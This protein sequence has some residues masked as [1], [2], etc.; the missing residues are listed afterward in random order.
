MHFW[1]NLSITKNLKAYDLK[2]FKANR[3]KGLSDEKWNE[4]VKE[5]KYSKLVALNQVPKVSRKDTTKKN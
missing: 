5:E 3:P 4:M 1:P 2:H